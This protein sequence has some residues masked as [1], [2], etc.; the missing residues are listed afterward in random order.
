M[1]SSID[2]TRSNQF[3]FL[4]ICCSH[5]KVTKILVNCLTSEG[6]HC[7]WCQS[8]RIG[9]V[10]DLW[11]RFEQTAAYWCQLTTVASLWS[12]FAESAHMTSYD[13][14]CDHVWPVIIHWYLTHSTKS[15]LISWVHILLTSQCLSF[16]GQNWHT[17]LS[18]FHCA[19]LYS[20]IG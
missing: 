10:Q 7:W 18:I 12:N 14:V 2:H 4:L 20:D 15:T 5:Q 17:A 3:Q 19:S 1:I 16:T 8:T 13:F 6:M 9:R 11:I